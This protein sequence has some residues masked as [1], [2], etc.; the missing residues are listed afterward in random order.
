MVK[1][2]LRVC[3]HPGRNAL[4]TLEGTKCGRPQ[5]ARCGVVKKHHQ[6]GGRRDHV[7]VLAGNDVSVEHDIWGVKL[8]MFAGKQHA[9]ARFDD[10]VHRALVVHF[11][12][13]EADTTLVGCAKVSP[14]GNGNLTVPT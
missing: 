1:R 10:R 11:G 12:R 13:E 5:E 9:Q 4:P 14:S 3:W 6:D 7:I 8:R 2:N